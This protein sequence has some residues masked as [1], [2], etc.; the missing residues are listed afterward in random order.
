[1]PRYGHRSRTPSLGRVG[2]LRVGDVMS[3]SPIT[4]APHLFVGKAR[5]A[6]VRNH[7]QYL[8][9]TFP[10]GRPGAICMHHLTDAPPDALVGDCI[11]DA[12]WLGPLEPQLPVN[13][14][15]EVMSERAFRCM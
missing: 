15:A 2:A 13:L 11:C 9:V 10:D 5:L 4:V 14:A 7:V 3:R 12:A 1:M 8:L 6:A